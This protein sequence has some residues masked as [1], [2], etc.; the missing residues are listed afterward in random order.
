[1]TPATH[2]AAS[3]LT[4][5]KGAERTPR[6]QVSPRASRSKDVPERQ[7]GLVP[8]ALTGVSTTCCLR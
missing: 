2:R 6:T 8:L 7:L 3:L 1:M 4:V 5:D